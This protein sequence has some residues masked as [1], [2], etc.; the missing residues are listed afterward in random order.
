MDQVLV[1][2]YLQP[3]TP[4]PTKVHPKGCIR[5]PL[6]CLLCDIYGTLLISGSGDIGMATDPEEHT[7]RID[8]LLF[9]YGQHIPGATL[10]KQLR[11]AI[12]DQHIQRR[13]EGID[14]PEVIIEQIWQ[15]LLPEMVPK[16]R[17]EFAVEFEM[18]HNPVWPM[19]GVEQ[20]LSTCRQQGIR[21][22]II[23]NAQFYTPYLFTWL[24][25]SDTESLGFD[26]DLTLYS[27]QFGH[28]KPSALLFETIRERLLA[29]GLKPG[30]VAFIGND[31]CNDILPAHNAGFQTI[32]FGGDQRSLRL[33][34]EEAACNTMDP[35]MVINH[36]DQLT[37]SLQ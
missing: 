16:L 27:F 12:S 9:R 19:P 6:A 7:T 28:A 11:Q 14:Y 37:F 29:T 30:S 21:L 15:Q 23:S 24:L 22:G 5:L 26:P 2:K 33:R 32:L 8:H 3:L 35:D 34:N 10:L 4:V 36:L 31:M 20:L 18:I 1:E 13:A 17:L 25:G